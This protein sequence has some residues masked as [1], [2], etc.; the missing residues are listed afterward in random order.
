MCAPFVAQIDMREWKIGL[1]R[2]GINLED[3]NTN[4]SYDILFQAV[5]AQKVQNT[6][7]HVDRRHVRT[8]RCACFAVTGGGR[9][10][11]EKPL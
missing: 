9:W 11:A 3:T 1:P 5:I 4:P 10:N 7:G 2:G 8:A 6:V